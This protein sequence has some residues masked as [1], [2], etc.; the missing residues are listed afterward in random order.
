MNDFFS[1]LT[2]TPSS[3]RFFSR[4]CCRA[5]SVFCCSFSTCSF[6]RSHD[7][8]AHKQKTRA[9]ETAHQRDSADDQFVRMVRVCLPAESRTNA[10]KRAISSSVSCREHMPLAK[11]NTDRIRSSQPGENPG[12][13]C[14]NT[15][16][17]V[18][19]QTLYSNKHWP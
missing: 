15:C 16:R 17:S 11:S 7:R 4:T 1:T 10:E 6:S 13:S 9:L 5:D 12:E 19:I 14:L 18:D 8:S 3:L 2:R